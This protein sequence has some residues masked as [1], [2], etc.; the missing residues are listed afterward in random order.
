MKELFELFIVFARVGGFTFGGGYAMLPILQQEVVEKRKWTTEKELMD[1][2]AIGQCTPGIIAI[3]TATFIGYKFKGFLGAIFATFGMCFPS[4]VIITII[5]VLIKNFSDLAIVH[6]AFAGIRVCVFVLI[7]NSVIKLYKSAVVDK[8]AL[9][10]FV[11][12]VLLSLFTN[13]A[14][15]LLVLFAGITGL[16]LK[17]IGGKRR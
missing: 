3:N 4:L 16:G 17:R 12:V 9:A 11:I 15:F 14:T 7:I 10:I 1:Y 5:T 8:G 13:I 6:N 2:Y